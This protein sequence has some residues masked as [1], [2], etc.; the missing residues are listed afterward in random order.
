MRQHTSYGEGHL[1]SSGRPEKGIRLTKVER[2]LW[3]MQWQQ[4]GMTIPSVVRTCHRT[5]GIDRKK[6][7]RFTSCLRNPMGTYELS[8]PEKDISLCK[9]D[10]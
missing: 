9:E 2:H 6:S 3:E 8:S 10:L 5:C 4:L 1:V 7:D